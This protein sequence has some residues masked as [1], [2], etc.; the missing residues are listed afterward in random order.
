MQMRM[1]NKNTLVHANDKQ[2]QYFSFYF[3]DEMSKICFFVAVV[4]S[5]MIEE[6]QR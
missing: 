2:S 3:Q 1:H 5:N 4:V 6:Q